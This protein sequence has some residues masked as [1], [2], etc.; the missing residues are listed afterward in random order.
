MLTPLDIHNHEFKKSFRGY[1]ENE[2]D[3]F[4]DRIVSDYEKVLRENEKLKERANLNEKELSHYKNL[5]QN[6]QDTLMIA[7]K[8]AEEVLNAAR[9]NAKE[10]REN[11]S[12]D[13]QRVHENTMREAQNIR[14][15]AQLDAKQSLDEAARK[16]HGVALEYDRL[17]REKN[18][19][20]LK[21]RTALES[22]LAV[23]IQLLASVPTPSDSE[24]LKAAALKVE[25]DLKA[26]AQLPMPESLQK[27]AEP[28][29]PAPENFSEQDT[30]IIST[31][32]KSK[33]ET[34]ENPVG[35][36]TAT[37]TPVKKN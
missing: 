20:L 1:D 14:V 11:A 33:P 16:L 23:V 22:E 12:N 18:S 9:K 26:A 24:S 15:Q 3:D 5:E 34:A 37:Y 19:F 8:T 35:D 31:K 29:N 30:K 25:Q 27:P 6:M 17:V 7:Q 10:I 32:K 4:L 28:Q 13:A 2:V 21:I 36:E